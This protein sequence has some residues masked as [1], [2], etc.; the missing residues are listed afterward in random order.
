MELNFKQF[1]DVGE[2]LVMVHGLFGSLENLAGIAKLLS[3]SFSVYSI[4]L[5]NHGRSPH[6]DQ[7]TL[8]DMAGDIVE[9]LDSQNIDSAYLF[10]HSLGGKAMMELALS[11]PER[12]K[13]V[14]VGDIAPV[15]YVVPRH[16]HIF[17]GLNAVDIDSVIARKDVDDVLANFIKEPPVRSFILKNLYKTESGH[18]AWRANVKALQ[19][20]YSHIIGANRS[21]KQYLNPILFLKGEHSDYLLPEHRPE[22]AKRFPNAD[23][24]VVTGTGHWLHAEKPN[25]VARLTATF[26]ND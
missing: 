5:R 20:N 11:A 13:K 26:L 3:D 1:S 22:V 4:D 12:A 19:V 21:D 2:P 18:F 15:D 10:G 6:S 14:V 7:M 25:M 8:A 9:F 17:A 23:L 16:E 24:K